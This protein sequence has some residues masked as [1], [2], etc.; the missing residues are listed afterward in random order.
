MLQNWQLAKFEKAFQL[1]IEN[2]LL[3]ISWVEREIKIEVRDFI[4]YNDNKTLR[5]IGGI[6]LQLKGTSWL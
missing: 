2:H 1:E 5:Q 4:K 3:N 6:Y